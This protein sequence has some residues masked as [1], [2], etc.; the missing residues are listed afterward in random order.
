MT[1]F[2]LAFGILL[3]AA[4]GCGTAYVPFGPGGEQPPE[5]RAAAA[6]DCVRVPEVALGFSQMG[7][8]RGYFWLGYT[9]SDVGQQDLNG[10]GRGDGFTFGAGFKLSEASHTYVEL[11]MEKSLKHDVDPSITLESDA[12]HE[13][14]L[15]GFRTATAARARLQNQ[16]TPYVTYGMGYNNVRVDYAAGSHYM[17][18]VGYY[19]GLGVEFPSEGQGSFSFDSKFHMW[20]DEY[21]YGEVKDFASLAFSLLWMRIF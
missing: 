8:G 19:I 7:G 10:V 1:R 4:G 21:Y 15:I 20:K 14:S 18:A 9:A 2:G 12:F 11:A 13:R 16:P 17:N 3:A 6:P 5:G